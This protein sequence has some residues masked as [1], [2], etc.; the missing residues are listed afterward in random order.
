MYHFRGQQGNARMVMLR[1]IEN[2]ERRAKLPRFLDTRETTRK[3]GR[4]FHR[5]ELRLRKRIVIGD[6]R[7]RMRTGHAQI[8]KQFRNR[9]R[10]HRPAPIRVERERVPRNAVSLAG[11]FD[12]L[13]RQMLTLPFGDKP[14]DDAATEN[15]EYHIETVTAPFGGAAQ[16]GDVPRPDLVRAGGA[17]HGPGMFLVARLPPP[18]LN[19]LVLTQKPVHRGDRTQITA[20][21]KERR[22][23][24]THRTIQKAFRMQMRQQ[25]GFFR[26]GEALG[27]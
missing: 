16:F 1:V 13:S 5:L 8:T 25:L 7:A 9:F 4:V 23:N 11:R 14:A 3:L 20:F 19:L 17:K 12:Q 6:A 22:V 21:V 2:Q 18:F 27:R 26:R 24:L 10:D 15:I